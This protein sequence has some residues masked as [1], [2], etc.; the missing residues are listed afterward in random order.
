MKSIAEQL[1]AG[2]TLVVVPLD[3]QPQEGWRL[4]ACVDSSFQFVKFGQP[5]MFWRCQLA[6]GR[7]V[8]G[9]EGCVW[10][11]VRCG[12][13]FNDV[14]AQFAAATYKLNERWLWLVPVVPAKGSES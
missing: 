14:L 12:D 8:P 1:A 3:P 9:R 13:R 2:A 4:N 5:S 10:G 11:D 7:P 6:A